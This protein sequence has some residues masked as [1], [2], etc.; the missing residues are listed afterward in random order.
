MELGDHLGLTALVD[1]A[2]E[3]LIQRSWL[4]HMPQL[5]QLLQ[6]PYF[7][8]NLERVNKLLHHAKRGAYTELQVLDLLELSELLD[9]DIAAVLA[10]SR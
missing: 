4:D 7:I 8:Q 10:I 3:E 9:D 1:S 5:K 2:A 6:L